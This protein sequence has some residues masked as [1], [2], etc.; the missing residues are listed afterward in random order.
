MKRVTAGAHLPSPHGANTVVKLASPH[1]VLRPGFST[2]AT[3]IGVARQ[4]LEGRSR[5]LG[6]RDR[7][8]HE[9]C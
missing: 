8:G 3:P 7:W 6:S 4:F 5:A 2:V 9:Q 1:I